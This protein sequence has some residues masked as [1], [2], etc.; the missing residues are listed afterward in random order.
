MKPR[1]IVLVKNIYKTNQKKVSLSKDAYLA[2][3]LLIS[4][5]YPLTSLLL[6]E[7]CPVIR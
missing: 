4:A 2:C 6:S 5:Y 7:E 1:Q 3:Y